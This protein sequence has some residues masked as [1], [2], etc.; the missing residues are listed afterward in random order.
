L[1]PPGVGARTAGAGGAEMMLQLQKLVILTM[2]WVSPESPLSRPPESLRYPHKG[3]GD[4]QGLPLLPLG[5]QE[6]VV[7]E[8]CSWCSPEWFGLYAPSTSENVNL[9]EF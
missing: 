7:A 3:D 6:S 8:G 9:V 5:R 4:P 1:S 2:G